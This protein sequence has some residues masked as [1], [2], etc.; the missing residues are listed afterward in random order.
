MGNTR[1]FRRQVDPSTKRTFSWW[2]D[3]RIWLHTRWGV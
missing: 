2:S 3:F 1:R